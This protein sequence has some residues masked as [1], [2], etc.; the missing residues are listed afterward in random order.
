MKIESIFILI[1]IVFFLTVFT[2]DLFVTGR[3]KDKIEVKTA[4]CWTAVWI[5]TALI[6]SVMIYFYFPNGHEK[7]LEFLASYLIEYSLSVD[8]LFVFIMI[9]AIMGVKDK[10]QPRILKWGIIGAIV[11]RIIFITGGIT[12]IQHFKFMI[13]I[14]GLILIYTAYKMLTSTNEQI[15]PDKNI[16]VRIASKI[17]KI[18]CD[19]DTDHFFVREHNHTYATLALVTLVLIESTDVIFAVDS[20]PAVLAITHDPFIA[21]TSNLF[22]IL[23]L[24]SLFFALAG[25]LY[26]FRFL[27]YGI[28]V[29]L[30]FVGVKMLISGYIHIS[31]QIS[32]GLIILCLIVSI[33]ASILIKAEESSSDSAL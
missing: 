5:S 21:I 3:R 28:S 24:R 8:N 13:Y 29:I 30:L 33:L 25:I 17:F 7:A 10:H 12:V 6:F 15:D 14:F 18:K 22:A 1:F 9:F 31:V 27:K 11:L 16:C 26:M 20:V 19:A 32:L 23:G 4:L 2:I